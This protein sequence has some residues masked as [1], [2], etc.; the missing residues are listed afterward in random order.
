MTDETLPIGSAGLRVGSLGVLAAV[1]WAVSDPVAIGIAVVI[2]LVWLRLETPYTVAAGQ[3]LFA[4]G[5]T[6]TGVT[7]VGDIVGV[8]S[9][10]LL[11][12]PAFFEHWTPSTAAVATGVLGSL[13]AVL[14][15]SLL[16]ESV[17][18]GAVVLCL[19][20]A[21]VAYGIHRYELV[22]FELVTQS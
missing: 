13:T 19:A 8:A 17:R 18:L 12:V 10:V 5:F 3:L 7:A 15:G 22:R 6:E 2:G 1:L 21:F 11:F 16:I 14:A 4:I 20:F 9:F